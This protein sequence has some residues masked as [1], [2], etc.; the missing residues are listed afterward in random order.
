[1]WKKKIYIRWS[2][3]MQDHRQSYNLD[4]ECVSCRN[5]KVESKIGWH[6]EQKCH[7]RRKKIIYHE[8]EGIANCSAAKGCI[9]IWWIKSCFEKKNR[10]HEVTVGMLCFLNLT[11]LQFLLWDFILAVE[12]HQA[13]GNEATPLSWWLFWC[14][15]SSLNILKKIQ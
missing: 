9:Q 4:V 15:T 11:S 14:L 1:M 10:G 12:Y 6:I 8:F 7:W 5:K 2:R 13:K 3:K